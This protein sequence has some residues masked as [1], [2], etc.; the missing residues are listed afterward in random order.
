MDDVRV[1]LAVRAVRLRLGWRQVDVATK[2]GLSHQIVS[3]I[4]RGRLA[5][6]SIRALRAVAAVLGIRLDLIA[7]WRGG[8]LDR[9]ISAR[10]AAM[11]EVAIAMFDTLPGWDIAS[12]VSYS[13][14]G[15]R[16]VI[17]LVGWH[18]AERALLIGELKSEF[19]DPNDLVGSMDRRK[20]L[21][22]GIVRDRGWVPR[23]VSVWVLVD[24]QRT[25]HRQLARH[26]R[27]LRGAFPADGRAMRKWLRAPRTPIAAL[28]FL[29]HV[30]H[31]R[32]RHRVRASPTLDPDT[33][34]GP[35]TT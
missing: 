15:E 14:Y 23:T 20:R 8:E 11:H 13:I 22:A 31:V 16:G 30:R 32:A 10:H 24:D 19:V 21:A 4:E 6:V 5:E 25:N 29:P 3:R 35:R 27:L 34:S 7:R 33:A 9:L 17:D 1:G 2:A 26:R 12:E 28:S 18:A